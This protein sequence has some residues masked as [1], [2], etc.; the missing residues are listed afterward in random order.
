MELY[1][2]RTFAAVAEFGTLARACDHVHLSQPAASAHIKALESELGLALFTREPKGLALTVAGTTLLV[3]AQ[4]MLALAGELRAEA[5]RLRGKLDARL[6]MGAFFD[7]AL[8]RIGELMR[9]LISR[10]PMLDIQ[11]HHRTS[12]A[13]IEG[14]RNGEFDAGLALCANVSSELHAL[15][16]ERLRYRIVAP[17]AWA[18]QLREIDWKAVA[19]LPWISTPADGSHHHMAMRIFKQHD[20]RP[21]KVMEA[22]SEA[23][24]TS[25]VFAGVGLGLMREDLALEAQAA[26]KAFVLARG[27]ATVSLMLLHQKLR[28]GDPAIDALVTAVR[29][30]WGL[31]VDTGEAVP[32]D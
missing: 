2:L 15:H 9:C 28:V 23:I 22:D 6:S 20:F 8:L 21:G 11:I 4:R 31:R 24:I 26:G 5:Q 3:L 19:A 14:V 18:D 7:P 27:E 29:E 16:L 17:A 25:L 13:V 32:H 10:H 1:Q 12:R 30:V